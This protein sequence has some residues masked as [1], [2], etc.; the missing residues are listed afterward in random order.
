MGGRLLLFA[1]RRPIAG[2]PLGIRARYCLGRVPWGEALVGS[3]A[4]WPVL[5]FEKKIFLKYIYIL[6]EIQTKIKNKTRK[7][8]RRRRLVPGIC[9]VAMLTGSFR[10]VPSMAPGGTMLAWPIGWCEAQL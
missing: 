2:Q 1:R 4:V 7:R 10:G 8:P 3:P 5:F 6:G 9:R